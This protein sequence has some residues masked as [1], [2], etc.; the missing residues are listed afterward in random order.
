MHKPVQETRSPRKK[1]AVLLNADV[2]GFSALMARDPAGTLDALLRSTAWLAEAVER[3]GGRVVDAPGDNLLAE[4]PDE[5]SAVRCALYVQWNESGQQTGSAD[6]PQIR[7]RIGIEVGEVLELCGALY[8]NAVNVAAR[9]QSHAAE[10]G[11]LVSQAVATRA[12]VVRGVPSS[13]RVLRLKNIPQSVT[14]LSFGPR[15]GG[16]L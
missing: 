15:C 2:V 6:A 11:V 13:A 3:Y 7:F 16:M 5:E 9:L 12:H 8:G 10:G 14:A 4:F 1:R